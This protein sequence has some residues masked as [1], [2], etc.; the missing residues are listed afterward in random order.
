MKILLVQPPRTEGTISTVDMMLSEP[1]ALEVLAANLTEHDVKILDM[2][3]DPDLEGA[4]SSFQP[5]MVGTTAFTVEVYKAY[6]ILKKAKEYNADILTVIGGQH[7]TLSPEDFNKEYIDIVAI[8]EGEYLVREIV[9]AQKKKSGFTEIKGLGLRV[10]GKF[11]LTGARDPIVD[12]DVLPFADRKLTSVY[13]EKYHRGVWKPVASIFSSRG[14]PFR[15]DYCAMWKLFKGQF[16][17]RQAKNFVDELESLPEKYIS[18]ADDN[19]LQNVSYAESIYKEIRDRNIKKSYKIYGRSDTIVKHPEIVDMWKSIGMELIFIGLEAIK[20]EDLKNRNKKNTVENNEKAVK[21]LHDKKVE[22]VGSFLV[23]QNF[24][25]KDFKDMADYV[26]SRDLIHPVF[27]ILTPFPGTDLYDKRHKEITTK[28][29]E[30]FDIFHSV[31][32]TKLPLKEFY[33]HFIGLYRRA[34]SKHDNKFLNDA[35]ITA[36]LSNLMSAHS[37]N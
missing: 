15:C 18:F 32:P 17:V 7:A 12:L 24:T 13:R 37:V 8:G 22:I 27:T 1:L 19:T 5:D 35:T 16:R 33:A 3:L 9:E 2:R 4:L 26:E 36:L 10:D 31:L 21:I 30:L 28:N 11:V 20:N 34:Y 23:D 25:E 6:G 29:Y 14:C